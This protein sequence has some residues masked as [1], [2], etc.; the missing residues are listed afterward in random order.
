MLVDMATDIEAPRLLSALIYCAFPG[1][2]Q[3]V[4]HGLIQGHGSSLLPL[5]LPDGLLEPGARRLYV[6][7][8]D[9]ALL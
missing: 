3:G 4:T 2:F 9:R 5:L 1:C 7:L 8:D 6:R